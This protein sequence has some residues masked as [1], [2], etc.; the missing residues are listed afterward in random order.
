MNQQFSKLKFLPKLIHECNRA[1]SINVC[2]SLITNDSVRLTI[3]CSNDSE[4]IC[5]LFSIN[6]LIIDVRWTRFNGSIVNIC[7]ENNGVS[8]VNNRW[9]LVICLVI[10][11]IINCLW[12]C[13]IRWNNSRIALKKKIKKPNENYSFTYKEIIF[14]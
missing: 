6:C 9:I 11:I 10:E 2:K 3:D 12:I 13:W 14:V 4:M 8:S 5:F 7:E 1:L